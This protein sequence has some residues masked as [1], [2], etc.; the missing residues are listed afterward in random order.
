MTPIETRIRDALAARRRDARGTVE[1][2]AKV[3]DARDRATGDH[4]AGVTAPSMRLALTL[5]CGTREAA[6][7][8]VAARLHD[9]GKVAMPDALLHKPGRLLPEERDQMEVHPDVGADILAKVPKLRAAARYVRGH[10]ERWDGAGYPRGLAR[11]EIALGA[12]I[13]AVVDAYSAMTTGRGYRARMDPD[14]AVAE[15]RRCAGR[16]FDPRVVEAFAA[17]PAALRDTSRPA[18]L[19]RAAARILIV[20]RI[21]SAR[22]AGARARSRAPFS[23]PNARRPTRPSPSAAASRSSRAGGPDGS[24]PFVAR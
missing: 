18:D 15:L 9:I 8:G 14:A 24:A 16:Q 2:L 5:G 22:R 17:F 13:I 19:G 11:E 6:V 21:D 1:A 7:V 3:I 20:H 4:G 23:S 12:R 10:H